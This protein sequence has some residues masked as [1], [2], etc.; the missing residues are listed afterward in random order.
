MKIVKEFKDFISRGNVLDVA[1]AFII[2]VQFNAVVT[3]FTNDVLMQVIGAIF[4]GKPKFDE[5]IWT[6]NGSGIKYGTFFTAVV[7]FVLVAFVLFLI[8]KAANKA[9]ALASRGKQTE[10]EVAK[11]ELDLLT[12]IRDALVESRN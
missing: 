2:G 11:T 6:V 10:E 9:R 3:S 1:I 4:G 12:E 5:Y 7:N 8:V